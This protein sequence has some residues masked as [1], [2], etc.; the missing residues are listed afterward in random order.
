MNSSLRRSIAV[1]ALMAWA[2]PHLRSQS[3][4]AYD[5]ERV[6]REAWHAARE[7]A[8]IG[9]AVDRLGPVNDGLKEIDRVRL[10]AAR[11]PTV[12]GARMALAL[13][14]A[15]AAVRAAISAAQDERDEMTIFIGYARSI[16]AQLTG[17]GA[18]AGWPL[19]IDELEGEL[20]FEVDRFNE[21]HDAYLRAI[22]KAGS[23]HAWIGLARS[24]DRLGNT[25]AACDAYRRASIGA[26]V[27]EEKT[28]AVNY[29][30]SA[31]CVFV[32]AAGS[33][34]P[35]DGKIGIQSW[36]SSYVCRLPDPVCRQDP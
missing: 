36:G 6:A 23:P 20:W 35:A 30:N 31:A 10:V 28:E 1:I 3:S 26:L 22:A 34:Q 13:R 9:G 8:S 18:A 15:D 17:L 11:T 2:V 33:R 29:L 27:E 21:A 5:A 32:S 16:D 7:L 19:P 12:E 25:L 24:N 14:Y 4:L